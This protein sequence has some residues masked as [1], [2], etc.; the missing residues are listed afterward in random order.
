MD[1]F[2]VEVGARRA[3]R[4][5]RQG[6]G[7]PALD[8]FARRDEHLV[9]VGVAGLV[10]EAVVDEH[11][12]AVSAVE[13]RGGGDLHH[14][15][16]RGVDR[17]AAVAAEV[18]A[19]VGLHAVQHGVVAARR[20]GADVVVV[21]RRAV[22]GPD[23]RHGRRELLLVLREGLQLVH[24]D[25]FEVERAGQGVELPPRRD[26]Q[27]REFVLL[28]RCVLRGGVGL[29][30]ARQRE[31]V[32]REERTVDVVVAVAHGVD[33][34][35]G[36]ADAL[37]QDAVADDQLAVVAVDTV[38]LRR[39]EEVGEEDVGDRDEDESDEDFA[40]QAIGAQPER[41]AHDLACQHLRLVREH[42]C[43]VCEAPGGGCLLILRHRWNFLSRQW[44][45]FSFNCVILQPEPNN[46]ENKQN[47]IY[48]IE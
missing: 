33:P 23:G 1:H 5:A 12:P 35:L 39:V 7:L 41:G 31:R 45:K 4:V 26:H 27:R 14:A 10:A 18:D 24:R 13:A 38:D 6:D 25:R 43:L 32:G 34:P 11:L 48:G 17:R 37:L 16:A 22:D 47:G 30:D 40:D 3:A 19:R 9:Q 46:A 8:L 36:R 29:P 44:C 15:V 21:Q 28:E 20:E 42:L 2:V